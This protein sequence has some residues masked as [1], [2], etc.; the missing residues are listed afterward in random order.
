MAEFSFLFHLRLAHSTAE[1]SRALSSPS[2]F[3][4]A[5][6]SIF[7]SGSVFLCKNEKGPESIKIGPISI[8]ASQ[9]THTQVNEPSGGRVEPTQATPKKHSNRKKSSLSIS[10]ESGLLIRQK[11]PNGFFA[12]SC[13]STYVAAPLRFS[14]KS[15][16]RLSS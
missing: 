4:F 15:R 7:F 2:A 9:T 16:R 5:L 1:S 12:S 6:V 13:S 14:D 11:P 8:E 3:P 10:F